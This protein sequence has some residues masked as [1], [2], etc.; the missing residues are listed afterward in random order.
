MDA[1]VVEDEAGVGEGQARLLGL[2]VELDDLVVSWNEV[3]ESSQR[4]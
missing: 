4:N 3:V 2:E 1:A